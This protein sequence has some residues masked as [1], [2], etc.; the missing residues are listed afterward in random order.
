M[1]EPTT[2]F[3]AA[4]HGYNREDVVDYID[5]MTREHEEALQHL[6]KANNKLKDELTEA[7]EALAAAK[8]NTETE[9]AL[10]DAQTLIADLRNLNED[11]EDRVRALEE[12][13]EQLRAEKEAETVPM[14]MVSEDTL[15]QM[16]EEK[17][18]LQEELAAAGET[19]EELKQDDAKLR[20]ELAEARQALDAAR[21]NTAAETALS[22]AE[23]MIANLRRL[24]DNQANRIQS[25]EEELK[26]GC[27]EWDT[28]S[29]AHEEALYRLQGDNDRLRQE[30]T[31]A[32]EALVAARDN[33]E[34]EAALAE[35]QTM[36]TNL[37][38]L[39]NNQAN[40]IQSL[41]EEMKKLQEELEAR[42]V[43]A[44][45]PEQEAQPTEQTRD[46]VEQELAAYRRAEQ[47]ERLARERAEEMYRQV[48]NVFGQANGR[49]GDCR[50]ELEQ[51]SQ[52]M[53]AKMNEMMS[54]ITSLN[55]TYRQTEESFAEI[56]A[57]DRQLLE[58][59][60]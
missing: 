49:I 51:I 55:N 12:E 1:P 32:H 26:S 20:A 44:T 34:D 53:T 22:E 18:K 43:P 17:S 11:L 40:R 45:S 48:Q 14:P 8:N 7:N 59:N 47:T 31:E 30:L 58:D 41:Q 29:Q 19:L 4:L 24:N 36:I 35:A 2:Q 6:Q 60:N 46:Y 33:S 10:S 56:G 21:E 42:A 3:R 50:A 16:Q 5:R 39:N 37:R 9:K 13:L 52:E 28:M 57:R 23:T 15:G 38:N 27:D 54:V 25:L